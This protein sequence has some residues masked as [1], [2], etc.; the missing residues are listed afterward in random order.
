LQV[1]G[2][3]LVKLFDAWNEG[4]AISETTVSVYQSTQHGVPEE[5]NFQQHRCENLKLSKMGLELRTDD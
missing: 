2:L 3:R 5:L 1:Q 4:N